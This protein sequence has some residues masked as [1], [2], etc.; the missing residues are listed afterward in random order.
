MKTHV[1]H[2]QHVNIMS[3]ILVGTTEISC[4]V[5]LGFLEYDDISD[6]NISQKKW[7]SY[8]LE[9]FRITFNMLVA[10]ALINPQSNGFFS[11]KKT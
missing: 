3:S 6:G 1:Y 11:C 2:F 8:K 9:V 7:L 10:H 5:L 4:Y